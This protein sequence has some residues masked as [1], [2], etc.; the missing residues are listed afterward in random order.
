MPGNHTKGESNSQGTKQTDRE[1]IIH[2]KNGSSSTLPLSSLST[3]ID[4]E[5]EFSKLFREESDNFGEGKERTVMV[6][7][8]FD[9]QE[10]GDL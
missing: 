2:I 10:R 7:R 8:K 3:S 1:V 9:S 4:S 5:I 6:E